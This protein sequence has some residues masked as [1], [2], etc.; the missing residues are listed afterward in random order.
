MGRA[1]GDRLA[2]EPSGLE[3]TVSNALD[4]IPA[5]ARTVIVEEL[6]HR[7]PS[8]LEQLR[9]T[10]EP[11]INQRDAVN[12]LLAIA[13]IKS[14]NPNGFRM[15]TDWQWSRLLAFSTTCGRGSCN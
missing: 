4:V 12:E 15:R 2:E 9:K 1:S 14:L 7:D 11:T 5:A 6:S 10:R 3:A 13:V 8:L